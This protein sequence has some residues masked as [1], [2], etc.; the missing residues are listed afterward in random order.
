MGST[1]VDNIMEQMKAK[2]IGTQLSSNIK[3]LNRKPPEKQKGKN[4]SS[5]LDEVYHSGPQEEGTDRRDEKYEKRKYQ[6]KQP[7]QTSP[8]NYGK[9]PLVPNV[10]PKTQEEIANEVQIE[11]N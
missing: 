2:E 3:E 1:N 11:R 4:W 9:N 8:K 10:K 7:F 6:V 5:K